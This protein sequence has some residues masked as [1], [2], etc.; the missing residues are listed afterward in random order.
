MSSPAVDL[1]DPKAVLHALRD[2]DQ[3]VRDAFVAALG[4]ELE[5]LA[6]GGA[7]CFQRLPGLNARLVQV[8]TLRTDLMGAFALGVL[9]DLMVSTKLLLGGKLPASGNVMRQAIEGIAMALLCSTDSLLVIEQKDNRPPVQA[10]YWKK[11][12]TGDTR[13]QGQHAIRQPGWNAAALGVKP[14]GIKRLR[15]AQPFFHPF[16]HCGQV[17][18]VHRAA[19]AQPGV[20]NLGGHF[21]EAKLDGY[22]THMAQRIGLCSVLPGF[23]DRLLGALPPAGAASAASNP[24]AQG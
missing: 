19:L 2:S 18:T 14:E 21:E 8:N 13:V 22:R 17:A 24:P 20:W 1:T 5:Q 3:R 15:D 23:L 6:A 12:W 4:T 10:R 16:S 9:D 7:T 11:V